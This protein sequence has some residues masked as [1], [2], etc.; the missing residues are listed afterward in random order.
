MAITEAAIIVPASRG[1]GARA[2]VGGRP[3]TQSGA[4]NERRRG[5]AIFA[6]RFRF[7][8]TARR[9]ARYSGFLMG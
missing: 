6:A 4:G 1:G 2:D 8:F 3:Q 5:K 7:Q 9:I